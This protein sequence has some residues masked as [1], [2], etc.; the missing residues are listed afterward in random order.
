MESPKSKSPKNLSVNQDPPVNRRNSTKA[1][2]LKNVK[3]ID[4]QLAKYGTFNGLEKKTGIPKVYLG[5]GFA[6]LMVLLLVFGLGAKIIGHMVSLVWPAYRSYVVIDAIEKL[7]ILKSGKQEPEHPYGRS[8]TDQLH[9]FNTYQSIRKQL[10]ME[11]FKHKFEDATNIEASLI[12][13]RQMLMDRCHEKTKKYLMYWVVYGVL[14]L[15]EYVFNIIMWWLPFYWTIKLI[16]LM[17]CVHPKYEGG[18]WV[19]HNVFAPVL[20]SRK[21]FIESWIVTGRE[22]VKATFSEI[23]EDTEELTAPLNKALESVNTG[24]IMEVGAT[25]INQARKLTTTTSSPSQEKKDIK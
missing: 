4:V 10:T 22:L 6:V 20:R 1:T 11:P 8:K 17:W 12:I 24:A 13:Q 2:L 5:I 16:F 14:Y 21:P 7:I 9:E 23:Q 19:Y 25:L 18:V 15:G 3:L